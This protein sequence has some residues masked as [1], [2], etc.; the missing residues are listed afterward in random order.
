MTKLITNVCK[1]SILFL[2]FTAL[3][4]CDKNNEVLEPAYKAV[5]APGVEDLQ[6]INGIAHAKVDKD[7]IIAVFSTASQTEFTYPY[8]IKMST[9]K[10]ESMVANHDNDVTKLKSPYKNVTLANRIVDN[11]IN[12]INPLTKFEFGSKEIFWTYDLS[13]MSLFP[14]L[15]CIQFTAELKAQGKYCNV[16]V[17]ENSQTIDYEDAEAIAQ[18]FDQVAFPIV[19]NQFGNPPITN[20]SSRVA[21]IM[22]LVF[23]GGIENELNPDG[24]ST[25]LFQEN[26]LSPASE[27]NPY[28]NYRNTIFLNI[29]LYND[30][31]SFYLNKWRSILSHEFQHMISYGYH[32]GKEGMPIEEGKAL[33]AEILSS[34]GLPNGDILQWSNITGYQYDPSG[35]SILQMDYSMDNINGTYGMGLLWESYIYDRFGKKAIYDMVTSSLNNLDAVEAITDIPKQ[36]LFAEW[37]QA[38][39]ISGTTNNKIFKYETIDVEGD[40]GGRYFRPLIGF[41]AL[42]DHAIPETEEQHEVLSYGVNYFRADSPGDLIIKGK[43]I[44]V[45]IIKKH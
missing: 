37:V 31:N 7:D 15:P 18:Q 38:N 21:I 39:I 2:V 29:G 14:N 8:S 5:L 17:D 1:L 30:T 34:Y 11:H 41:A 23:N 27:N 9:L 19:T 24:G 6:F 10:A 4:C 32:K 25:G 13:D 28:S 26:D 45:F 35:I 22:P 20:S 36:H 3:I 43:N 44:K 42:P 40:G 33:L 12:Y 16:Y